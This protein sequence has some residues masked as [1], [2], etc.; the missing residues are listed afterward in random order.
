M[1]VLN[2]VGRS[3]TAKSYMRTCRG[4]GERPTIVFEYQETRGGYHAQQF[5]DGFNGYLQTDAYSGY[6]WTEAIKEII[7]VGCHAHARRPKRWQSGDR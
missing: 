4:G 5:L 3:N 7:P 1:Q 2:E 6:I